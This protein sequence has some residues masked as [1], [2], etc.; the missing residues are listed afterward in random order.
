[1][2]AQIVFNSAMS[3][4]TVLFYARLL[5]IFISWESLGPMLIMIFKM[6]TDVKHFLIFFVLSTGSFMLVTWFLARSD[7]PT[8][9][10]AEIEGFENL[11]TIFATVWAG[12]WY[13]TLSLSLASV[14]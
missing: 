9:P 10:V 1:M 13:V 5:E 6:I 2:S 12:W 8:G 14:L 7:T 4:L 3:L 11:G